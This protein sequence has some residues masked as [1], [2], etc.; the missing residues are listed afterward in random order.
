M[1]S[2]T[3]IHRQSAGAYDTIT[4]AEPEVSDADVLPGIY[5]WRKEQNLC[6]KDIN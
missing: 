4:A 3:Y 5:V 2:L 1:T 6:L